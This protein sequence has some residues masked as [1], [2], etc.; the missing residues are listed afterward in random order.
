MEMKTILDEAAIRR[1]LTRIAHEIIE[2][3]KGVSE[4]VLVGIRTRGIYL[5]KRL[6][7]RIHQIEGQQVPVGELDITLYRDDLTE[8]TEQPEVRDSD[9]PV[10]IHGKTVVLV[11][12]VLFTGRTV[13]AAMDAL[14]DQGR[15]KMIQLAVLVDRGHRELPIRPDYIGKNVPT[16]QSEVVTVTVAEIDLQ[17]QVMIRK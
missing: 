5:A 8:K 17:D 3:N 11:D 15:P 10:S 1:A 9:L 6:A 2:R 14:I 4:T 7:E 13:R 16:S 12:D